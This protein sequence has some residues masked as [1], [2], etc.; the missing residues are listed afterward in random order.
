MRLAEHSISFVATSLINSVIQEHEFYLSY[1][2]K[3]ILNS[4]FWR[5]NVRVLPYV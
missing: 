2:I 5:K 1:D 4:Y 3:F